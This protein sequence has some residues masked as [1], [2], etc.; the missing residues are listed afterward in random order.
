MQKDLY[1]CFVDYEKAFDKVRHQDLLEIL[2]EQGLDGKD[3]RLIKNLYW[4]QRAGVRVS[5]EV[6]ELQE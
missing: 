4:N 1:I 6:S 5:G 3:L 2:E